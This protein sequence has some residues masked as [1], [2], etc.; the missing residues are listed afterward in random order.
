MIYRECVFNA[1]TLE[2]KF[3]DIECDETGKEISRI[4]VQNE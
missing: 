1:K 3:Y 4:E 2:Q